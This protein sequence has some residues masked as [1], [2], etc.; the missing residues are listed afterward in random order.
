MKDTKVV[1]YNPCHALCNLL[2]CCTNQ[3]CQLLWSFCSGTESL[4]RFVPHKITTLL[5]LISVGAQFYKRWG[6]VIQIQPS[7]SFLSSCV[8]FF[9]FFK[10]FLWDFCILT[11]FSTF[12]PAWVWKR[13]AKLKLFGRSI[14]SKLELKGFIDRP[15]RTDHTPDPGEVP[16]VDDGK[17][18]FLSTLVMC[19]PRRTWWFSW[20]H[21]WTWF[22]HYPPFSPLWH[23]G[24]FFSE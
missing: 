17:A 22:I 19:G 9:V 18:S 20:F 7:K 10:I 12:Y 2:S 1:Q 8:F 23:I 15:M 24:R 5:G 13:R 21:L 14:I 16:A 4:E 3:L 11:V 6:D